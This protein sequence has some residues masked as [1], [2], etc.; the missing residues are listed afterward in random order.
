MGAN[1]VRWAELQPSLSEKVV[2]EEVR[3]LMDDSSK[4]GQE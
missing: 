2:F 3:K 1:F 4:A